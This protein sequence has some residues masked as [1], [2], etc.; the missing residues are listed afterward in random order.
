MRVTRPQRVGGFLLAGQVAFATVLTGGAML[1]VRAYAAT[2]RIDPGFDVSDTLTLQLTLPRG[3]YPDTPSRVRFAERAAAEIAALPGVSNAGVVSDLPFVGNAMHFPV[4][5]DGRPVETAAQMTVRLADAGF[6]R[7]LRIPLREGRTFDAGDRADAAP[8]AVLNR[9]AAARLASADAVDARIR[10]GEEGART[11]VGVVGDIRHAGLNALEGPVVY[12]PFAQT[13]FSFVNWMGIVARGPGATA[14]ASAVK[15]AIARVD[16]AQPVT[17][18]ESMA[19]YVARE[20]APFR[21]G[22]L[23][24]GSLAAAAYVLALTGIYGLTA[25][26]VGRRSRELGVRLA[27]GASGGRIVRLV[28]GPISVALAAGLLAGLMG[29]LAANGVLNASIV[30]VADGAWDTVAGGLL[31]AVTAGITALGPALRAAHLDPKI[32]LQAE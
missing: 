17:A 12:V 7:T 28:L 9:T 20:T 6:F 22:S 14:A 21:F 31:V 4:R 13:S 27:L 29:G 18:V 3:R 10:L 11:V 8:V 16:P 23:V 15:A 25:F 32:A 24:I 2:T 26:I 19:E 30:R 5:P 1:L